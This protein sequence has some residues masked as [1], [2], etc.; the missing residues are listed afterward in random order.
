MA[1]FN[2][3]QLLKLTP[4]PLGFQQSIIATDL[5]NPTGVSLD[6]QGRIYVSDFSSGRIY[7]V[8]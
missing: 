7:L 3:G 2:P 5:G 4:S 1:I 6:S 8:Y